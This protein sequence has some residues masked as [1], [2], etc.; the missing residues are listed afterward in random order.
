MRVLFTTV[1][2]PG[3]FLPLVPLVWAFRSFGHDVLVAT[4]EEFV[5]TA[6]RT[7]IPVA[8]TG[9][10]P[11]FVDLVAGHSASPDESEQQR[12]YAHGRAFGQIAVQ[13]LP[14]VRAIVES[15][16]PDLV[17]SERAEFAGPLAAAAQSIPR[18]EYQWGVAALAEF[19]EA[20]A[21][22]LADELAAAG[23]DTLP[24]PATVLNPWPPS[25]RLEH[26]AGQQ[27]VRYVPF[28]GDA[29]VPDWV[30]APRDK[31]RICMTLGTL[32]PRFGAEGVHR[33]LLPML[34][35]VAELGVELVVAVDPKVAVDWPPLPAAVR[36]VGWLPLAQV[37]PSCD[38]LVHHGGQ[39][40]SLTALVTGTPQVVLPRIDDQWSNAD[41]VVASGAG[42]RF[43]PDEV[44]ADAVA[45]GCGEL[46]GSTRFGA[47]AK[48]VA[49]EMA[50]QPCLSEIV[51]LL[52]KI[53]APGC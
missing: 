9:K 34:E 45:K 43:A 51:G 13:A 15:W 16:R 50:A 21:V 7:G 3:H 17:V 36:H 32:L 22:E 14:G 30:L 37:L 31:P 38:A 53:G 1:A 24:E 11:D 44:T 23:K 41:A 35:S 19:A 6:L 5:P 26:A 20:A 47:A 4:S 12:R 29:F 25:L 2:L 33:F 18:V 28:N 8:S 48:Q 27:S 52:E 46:L 40:T 42:L 39:G 10:I 49:E